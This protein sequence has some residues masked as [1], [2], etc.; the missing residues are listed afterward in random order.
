MSFGMD[1]GG[2][3]RPRPHCV[4]WE[5]SSPIRGTTVPYISAGVYCGQMAGWI[6]MAL[7]TEIGLNADDIVLDDTVLGSKRLSI[8]TCHLTQY[9][10][11]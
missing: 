3:C 2:T 10:L 6:K 5:P 11:R 9:R 8:C 1:Y 7:G 4:T